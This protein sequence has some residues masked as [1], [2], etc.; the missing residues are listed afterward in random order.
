MLNLIPKP[1]SVNPAEGAFEIKVDTKIFVD[2]AS[3]ELLAIGHHLADYLNQVTSFRIQVEVGRGMFPPGNISLTTVDA[4]TVLGPEGYELNVISTSVRVA[5]PHAAGVFYGV[6]TLLQLIPNK[7][8]PVEIPCGEIRDFPRFGW[9]GT[10]LDVARHFFGVED[11]KRY[12]DLIA[13]YKLNV[14]HLHLTDD[15]GWRIE[16]K[17]WPNLTEHGGST[18]INGDPGGFYTQDQYAEIV[19]YAQNRYITIVPEIDLPGHTNA[20]LASYPELNCDNVAPELYTGSEVGFSSL[21]INKEITYQFVEDVI[22]E[23]AALTPGPYLHIGGDEAHSTPKKD[24]VY[25]IERIAP[26]ISKYG[27]QLV[28]WEEIVQCNLSPA[29]IMQYWTDLKHAEKAVE[30]GMKILMSPAPRVYIDMKYDEDTPLGLTWAGTISVEKAYTWD[31]L[32]E[33]KGL[34]ESVIV[35]VEAPLWS[36][37][38]RTM[39]DVNYMAFP[40]LAGIAEIAWSPREGRSW[41]EYRQRLV[42]HGVRWSAK[43]LNFYR[44]PEIPWKA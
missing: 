7:K 37:T 30:K 39:E 41:D 44:S 9:R 10:M 42:E 28:G 38:L 20:A 22:R 13:R 31:P 18:A 6:Q 27:K 8:E 12:I 3:N 25:F 17:S 11:V 26:F 34:D 21:C 1:V 14:L 40:R 43:G 33:V 16:I 5:A 24:Y 19:A 35:G 15:Q 36:E 23:L 2:P 32:T 29:S 4:D